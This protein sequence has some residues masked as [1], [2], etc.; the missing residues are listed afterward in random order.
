MAGDKRITVA[1]A[2]N[3]NSGKTSLFNS[4]A[5]TNLK[6][7]NWP[8]VTVEKYEAEIAYRGYLINFI[9]LPGTYSLTAYSPEE[10]VARDFISSG[11]ADVIVNV[12]DGTNLA[13]SL[14]LSVQLLE[15]EPKTIMALNMYDEVRARGIT[16]DFKM[17]Q[18]L[19]GCHIVPISAVKKT[20]ID[21]LLDHV[22][23]LY[24]G[25]ITP[26]EGKLTYSPEVED[27]IAK[28]QELLESDISLMSR[29]APRLAAIKLLEHD[30][31]M[32]R[33]AR[34][35]PV[36]IRLESKLPEIMNSLENAVGGGLQKKIAE[37]RHAF[38]RGAFKETVTERE[39]EKKTVTDIIDSVVL[40]RIF[41]LPIFFIVMWLIFQLTFTIGEI[42]MGWIESFFTWLGGTAEALIPGEM[43]R[44]VIVDGIIAGVGGVLVFIPNILLLFFGLSFLEATGYMAR[45]AFVIDKAF[46]KIGLHGKSFIPMVT[47]FGCSV[48][49]F[50]ACRTL[51]NRGDRLATM[52]VIPFMSCGA[53]LPLYV[54]LIG[55]FFPGKAAGNILFAVYFF[56]VLVAVLSAKLLKSTIFRG[57]SE[58]FVMELPVYRFPTAGSVLMQMWIK[59]WM[60][61]KKAG[62]LILAASLI[63]WVAINFPV[64]RVVA[65][66]YNGKIHAIEKNRSLEDEYKRASITALENEKSAKLLEHSAAGV[67]GK[68]IEPA[69]RPLG[70]NWRIGV[71]LTAGLAAKEV[72]VSTMGTMYSMKHPGEKSASLEERLRNDPEYNPAVA[73]ALIVFVLLYMPCLAATSVFHREAG[74]LKMT[75]FYI[76][77]SMAT[78]WVLS[79]IVYRIALLF[80]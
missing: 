60:Y 51:K 29:V 55:A 47:G 71:A 15:F 20:G 34:G 6:V 40:N 13:R 26:P 2:G 28:T 76:A 5:G 18:K 39:E 4:I 56:G 43:L 3:P 64:N 46:H 42:P 33:I 14:Y 31:T 75:F 22:V 16:I 30:V 35:S 8:G 62:T 24:E 69:I 38:V 36:W 67:F 80:L 65:D 19:L 25:K 9:D 66:E 68:C 59:A 61:L 77:Y 27:A 1:F 21:S 23:R 57:R 54:L 37:D 74:E 72:V 17:L 73:L 48:P 44:S 63:I 70:F 11:Q 49:A 79:F 7:G 12:A 78:A 50:M 45:A 41:G 32:H 10:I 52:M 58:P 53:K